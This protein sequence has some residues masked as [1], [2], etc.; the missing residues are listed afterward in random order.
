VT[1]R[2]T[3]KPAHPQMILELLPERERE[4]FVGQ[5]HQVVYAAHD[6]AGYQRLRRLL[7]VWSLTAI[8]IRQPGHYE[9]LAA[10]RTGT[11]T[12]VGALSSNRSGPAGPT[13]S[14]PV[15][16]EDRGMSL[17]RSREPG[18]RPHSWTVRASEEG[19]P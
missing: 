2:P 11:A 19:I 3:E 7:R 12:T 5:H 4:E 13:P 1:P 18:R 15:N 9:E 8:A 16:P 14:S 10:A 6:P 17:C